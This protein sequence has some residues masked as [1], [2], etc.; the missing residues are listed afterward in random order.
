MQDVVKNETV[1]KAV[2]DALVKN[3][4]A[5]HTT[6][7]SNLF[8]KADYSTKISEIEEKIFDHNHDKYSS[9]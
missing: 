5:I 8:K 3:V 1:K 7:T 9:T 4:N 6:D 2:Y